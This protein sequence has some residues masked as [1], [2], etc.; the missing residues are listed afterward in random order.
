MK[1][2]CYFIVNIGGSNNEAT[3]TICNQGEDYFIKGYF[4]DFV[5]F[6]K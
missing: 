1:V 2:L 5:T 6:K 3:G 4:L